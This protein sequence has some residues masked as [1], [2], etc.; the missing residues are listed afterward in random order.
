MAN[1]AGRWMADYLSS[2]I[3]L[4]ASDALV[5]V[6]LHPARYRERGYN[7]AMLLASVISEKSGLRVWEVLERSKKTR[8]QFDLDFKKRSENVRGAFRLV[9]GAQVRGKHLLL[10]DDVATTGSTLE[11]CARVFKASGASGVKALVL[12]R[13]TVAVPS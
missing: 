7:Q 3:E 9:P 6:P 5:P 2:T 8:P 10:I 1:G 4:I 12:A 11:E 13:Q